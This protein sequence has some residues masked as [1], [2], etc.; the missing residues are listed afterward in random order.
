MTTTQQQPYTPRTS[1]LGSPQGVRNSLGLKG[2]SKGE[3]GVLT[4]AFVVVIVLALVFR[5]PAVTISAFGVLAL[6]Y[7]AMTRKTRGGSTIA[8]AA[9]TRLRT[10]EQR[11]SGEHRYESGAAT[12]GYL[13]TGE[14]VDVAP[15]PVVG[16]LA[17]H[18]LPISADAG[19]LGVILDSSN[20]AVI[21]A[22]E[23]T[24]PGGM[25]S[26]D[27]D[28]DT[29][30][31][32]FGRLM[33]RL[34]SRTS[35]IDRVQI[36]DVVRPAAVDTH[37]Q[38]VN[39]T[40]GDPH[41]VLQASYAELLDGANDSE[42]HRYY[43]VARVTTT[44]DVAA[45]VRNLAGDGDTHPN[46]QYARMMSAEID[47]LIDALTTA[48]Y[49][50]VRRLDQPR[51]CAL[52]RATYDPSFALDDLRAAFPRSIWP[53]AAEHVP[54]AQG[55]YRVDGPY[56][57][58]H[59]RT[60]WVSD[61]PT[62][63]VVTRHFDPLWTAQGIEPFCR[64]NVV[65]MQLINTADARREAVSDLT[66]D[67][68]QLRKDAKADKVDLDHAPMTQS[69]TR[70]AD[71]QARIPGVSVCIYTTFS[72]TKPEALPI[73]QRMLDGIADDLD[74]GLTPMTDRHDQGIVTALPLARGIAR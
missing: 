36:I 53:L 17:W 62:A 69:Q 26:D 41:P 66:L 71:H 64:T 47:A 29:Q 11:R 8:R 7:A 43:V 21:A 57:Q 13:D 15:P 12:A 60:M 23:V 33:Q 72:S 52:A 50:V 16:P 14:P 70:L 20:R 67:T 56:A 1:L 35:F 55:Y 65:V 2:L 6:M 74:V 46:E 68:S 10:R 27:R 51:L 63:P 39:G 45:H 38:W 42:D 58:W 40:K 49:R 4:L 19:H 28:Q 34:A 9:L 25:L 18:N 73:I 44:A 31:A 59:H 22:V 61:W 24:P 48:R 5:L 54:G 30:A 37:R 3:Q 32:R